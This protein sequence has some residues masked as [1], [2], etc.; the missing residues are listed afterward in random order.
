MKDYYKILDLD[1]SNCNIEII[2]NNYKNK[3]A[4]FIGLPFLTSQ[5]KIDIKNIKEA[6]Y[7]MTFLKEK[8]DKKLAVK[9]TITHDISRDINHDIRQTYDMKQDKIPIDNTKIF[10]RMFSL[11]F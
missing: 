9:N 4:R 7:V 11:T 3:I 6:Y 2:K 1:K 10:N 8:Y 5:M